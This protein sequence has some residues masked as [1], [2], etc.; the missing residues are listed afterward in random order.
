[1]PPPS[2]ATE[3]IPTSLGAKLA[4]S[5]AR[6]DFTQL[7]ELL[8]PDIEF[9]ALTPRRAWEPGT[10]EDVVDVL[11]TW[12]ADCDIQDVLRV[13]TSEISGRRH[14]TYRYQGER[15]DGPFVIEQQ[16]Y[17]DETGGQISWIRLLCSGFRPR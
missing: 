1:M 10:R 4:H 6:Q 5:I 8:H 15:P 11:R 17:Y 3:T 7:A 16:A 2:S 13:D 12:F 14:V 9:R